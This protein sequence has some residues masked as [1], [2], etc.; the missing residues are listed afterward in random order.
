[1]RTGEGFSRRHGEEGTRLINEASNRIQSREMRAITNK[2]LGQ[3][4]GGQI[5]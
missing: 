5:K 1:M 3:L 2:G 4:N